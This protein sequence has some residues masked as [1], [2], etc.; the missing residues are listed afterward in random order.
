MVNNQE[1]DT[2]CI[3]MSSRVPYIIYN[4]AIDL[5][6]IS[7]ERFMLNTGITVGQTNI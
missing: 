7:L 1:V 4:N 6:I 5:W 3:R 2:S